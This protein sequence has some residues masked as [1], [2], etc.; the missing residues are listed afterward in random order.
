MPEKP[1]NGISRRH[2]GRRAALAAT[3]SAVDPAALVAQGRGG[4]PLA[5]QDQA[6]VD[7]KYA[8]V[9][10]KYSDRLSDEQK[11]RARTVLA[12]HQRML[13]RIRE[14]PL[15]NGDGPATVLRLNPKDLK[16]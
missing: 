9:V 6:E 1:G 11:T 10:R 3:V 2:F 12:Q 16:E 8:D 7:A 13:R 14:F 4:Q 15:E 5:P